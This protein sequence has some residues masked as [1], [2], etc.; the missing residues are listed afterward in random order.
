M[1]NIKLNEIK[2][3]LG[4]RSPNELIELCLKLSKFKRDNKEFLT[5]LLFEQ[6]S[7]A[8]Y[9]EK[10]KEEIDEAFTEVSKS[11]FYLTKKGIRKAL[12][13]TQKHIKYSGIKT[14]EIE[15]LAYFL[16]HFDII[17]RSFP[18]SS[19]LENLRETQ[20]KR[21]TKALNNIHPDLQHDYL[22]LIQ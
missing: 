22:H 13:L 12:K 6:D 3:E 4:N 21:I 1:E 2:K 10:V 14:T 19:V 16:S 7:E 8:G 9:V 18:R 20:V 11:S 15:L 17:A 5:Y